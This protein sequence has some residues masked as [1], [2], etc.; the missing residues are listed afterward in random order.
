MRKDYTRDKKM[1][2][3][4]P[5]YSISVAA[6]LLNVHPRT[7][8][9]YEKHGLIAPKRRGNRRFFSN[10]DLRW[11]RCLREMIHEEGLSI[12]GI[13]ILLTLIPCWQIKG[14]S[15]RER[16]NCSAFYNKAIPCWELT[17]RICKEKFIHTCKDCKVYKQRKESIDNK[18]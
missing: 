18:I 13:R 17:R 2:D 1:E 10:S 7:L 16:E 12:S 3:D 4:R 9:L 5:V 6:E 14:C 8:R 11:I 15:E